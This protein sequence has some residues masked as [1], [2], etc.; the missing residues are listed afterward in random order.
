MN[1]ILALLLTAA[2]ILSTQDGA[3]FPWVNLGGAVLFVV[4]Y[5][6]TNYIREEENGKAIQRSVR[7]NRFRGV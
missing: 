2:I 1:W 4:V 3:W 6:L 7:A 5:L